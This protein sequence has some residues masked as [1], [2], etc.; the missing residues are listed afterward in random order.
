MLRPSKI[1]T[2]LHQ[3]RHYFQ[4]K[5]SELV[6]PHSTNQL[7][8]VVTTQQTM[9]SIQRTLLQKT[10][11]QTTKRNVVNEK[12]LLKVIQQHFPVVKVFSAPTLHQR[13]WA[14]GRQQQLR[15]MMS[16]PSSSGSSGF[17]SWGLPRTAA[18]G[19]GRSPTFA[20]QFS[21]RSPSC[22]TLFQSN[23]T[24]NGG[25]SNVFAH[26]SSRIFSPAGTKMNQ[27]DLNEKQS[28]KSAAVHPNLNCSDESSSA[29]EQ[30]YNHIFT[31]K[32]VNKGMG[33]LVDQ[34][35][36][37]YESEQDNTVSGLFVSRESVSSQAQQ[38]RSMNRKKLDF[39]IQHD[40]LSSLHSSSSRMSGRKRHH[41]RYSR[42][43][44]PSADQ[45]HARKAD[46]Q[47]TM[48][49][50]VRK[51]SNSSTS[52]TIYLLITLDTLQFLKD[53]NGSWS[54]ESL[55]T[56]FVDSIETLAYEYQIHINYVL[57]L[58]DNLQRHGKFRVVARQSELRIYFPVPPKSKQDAIDFLCLYNI[59]DPIMYEKQNYFSIIE[60]REIVLPSEDYFSYDPSTATV[61]PDY[62]KDLQ[63]FLDRTDYL[64][65]TSPAFN[66]CS[67][68]HE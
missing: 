33:D 44:Q 27:P 46:D 26:I 47:I 31:Q 61:G 43:K 50:N 3:L 10:Y 14:A 38:K 52:S 23:T 42:L 8:N 49:S 9:T 57:K 18:M 48:K 68:R 22:V 55:S 60:D 29:D 32:K 15:T 56:S 12:A 64:I 67:R 62:F 39:I 63:A 30:P 54:T 58:L 24:A 36:S 37:I 5:V 21:T 40:D 17:L 34:Q 1:F 2:S 28:P 4:T 41:S 25:Q 6:A 13:M 51:K 7:R 66:S 53:K 16:T 20:R 65:E 11:Q 19:V 35:D 59:V 45:H